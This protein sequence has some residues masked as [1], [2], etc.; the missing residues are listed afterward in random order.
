MKSLL[1]LASLREAGSRLKLSIFSVEA[2]EK[3]LPQIRAEAAFLFE[4]WDWL[5]LWSILTWTKEAIRI[6][7]GCRA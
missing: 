7:W 6:G 1:C 3:S 4:N 2:P 5:L